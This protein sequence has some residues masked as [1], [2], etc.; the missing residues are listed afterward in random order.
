MQLEEFE[1]PEAIFTDYAYFSSYSTAGCEHAKRYVETDHRA[2]RAR[3]DSKVVEI[4]S[5]DGY[6]LQYFDRRGVPVLGI[7]PAANVAAAA[8]ERGIPTVV[9]FFGA[10]AATRAAAEESPRR[11]ARRQQRARATSPTSTTSSPACERILHARTASLTM[12]FPHLS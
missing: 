6:L 12:E 7:E 5:N 10:R 3:R 1:P 4:A 8:E 2:V 11:P 9:E